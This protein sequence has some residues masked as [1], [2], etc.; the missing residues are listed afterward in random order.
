MRRC[1][2]P[3][4]MDLYSTRMHY[5]HQR[6]FETL[7]LSAKG[8]QTRRGKKSTFTACTTEGSA[9]RSSQTD[10]TGFAMAGHWSHDVLIDRDELWSLQV[11]RQGRLDR[12]RDQEFVPMLRQAFEDGWEPYAPFHVL[13]CLARDCAN[14]CD[15]A[16]SASSTT[17]PEPRSPKPCIAAHDDDS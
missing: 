6:P 14:F 7:L 8:E 3:L 17:S 11:L 2:S 4:P 15:F 10:S 13:H 1:R 12:H 9:W 5:P 16:T